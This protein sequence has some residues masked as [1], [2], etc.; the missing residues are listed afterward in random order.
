MSISFD[1]EEDLDENFDKTINTDKELSK[2]M[3]NAEITM[4]QQANEC[5]CKI[6]NNKDKNGNGFLC[7]IPFPDQFNLLPVLISSSNFLKIEEIRNTTLKI[8]IN[9][10]KITKDIYINNFRKLYSNPEYGT[11]IIEIIPEID[12]F[13]SFLELDE[14][15]FYQDDLSDLKEKDIYIVT[16]FDEDEVKFSRGKIT[17]I[18]EFNFSHSCVNSENENNFGSP[19]INMENF[20]V[21]GI[22]KEKKFDNDNKNNDTFIKFPC[23]EFISKLS[24]IPV[25]NKIII[26]LE[27][28][29][30][31]VCEKVFFLD[32][33]NY[34][35]KNGVSHCHNNIGELTVYNT[36]LFINDKET[37][38]QKFIVPKPEEIGTI[39]VRLE[40]EFNLT[41]CSR[42]F[43]EC[44]NIVEIDLS[45][46]DT[47]QVNN[48]SFMFYGCKNL[49]RLDL[50]SMNS[51]SVTDTRAMFSRCNKL[52]NI[53]FSPYFKSKNNTS[54]EQMFYGCE[55][56]KE[57]DLMYFNT[58]NVINMS[59]MC[60]GCI[61][62]TSVDLSSFNTANVTDMSFMFNNCNSI[63]ILSLLA[64]DTKKVSDMRAMF[65]RCKN[66]KNL[67]LSEKF[68][69]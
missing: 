12:G 64:F 13:N 37:R 26:K 43:Y 19:I 23:Q 35:D 60:N 36:Q 14:D 11:I 63:E 55:N 16:E 40:F 57:L 2:I 7:Q 31:D 45:N 56:L 18:E 66:L 28:D 29:D 46:C 1:C 48:M 69:T 9:N 59:G 5:I 3:I 54:M 38:Y 24:K 44:E 8:T 58:Q 39:I 15:S 67:R 6:T 21:I 68:N 47:Q 42:M 22:I 17:E 41:N 50:S 52:T 33:S 4:N 32:N 49:T 10:G 20:G 51:I 27:I 53:L 61:N 25:K 62:M 65:S 30:D 34:K